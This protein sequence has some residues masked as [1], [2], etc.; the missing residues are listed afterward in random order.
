MTEQQEMLGKHRP[1][2]V[3]SADCLSTRVISGEDECP[4]RH[5]FQLADPRHPFGEFCPGV[6]VVVLPR[7]LPLA[8]ATS[9]GKSH[10]AYLSRCLCRRRPFGDQR[11][12]DAAEAEA[13]IP[14]PA[15]DLVSQP[16]AVSELN[17]HR[18]CVQPLLEHLKV[19]PVLTIELKRVGE[20]RQDTAQ[21]PHLDEGF[22][23]L[24]ESIK[25]GFIPFR[26]VSHFLI[27]FDAEKEGVS[28][29]PG[30]GAQIGWLGHSVICGVDFTGIELV[31]VVD[32]PFVFW[33]V[34]RI[35]RIY[36]VVMVEARRPYANHR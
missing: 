16:L 2:L 18:Q 4:V 21:P 27:G 30:H 14:Q 29:L 15:E 9:S 20:Q 3:D 33:Q 10:V 23:G 17:Y 7:G 28:G 31:R 26:A 22:D 35:E 1:E 8:A 34:C 11:L 32:Q 12:I 36:P 19:V 6:G 5:A 25:D 24:T 13:E